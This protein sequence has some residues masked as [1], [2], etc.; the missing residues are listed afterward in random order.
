MDLIRGRQANTQMAMVL[1]VP[2]EEGPAEAPDVLDANETPWELRLVFQCL[3]VAFREWVAASSIS[4][5]P[6]LDSRVTHF[7]E[8][9]PTLMAAQAKPIAIYSEP[10]WRATGL[11]GRIASR[12]GTAAPADVCKPFRLC[13][14]IEK[15]GGVR[16]S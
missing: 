6:A 3:E 4:W 14:C 8:A 16:W 15:N 10:F 9:T 11:S 5:S 1:V 13:D 12:L 7:K 2:V